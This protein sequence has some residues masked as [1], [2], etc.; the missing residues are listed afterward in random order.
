MNYLNLFM[1]M[2][3]GN[4][5]PFTSGFRSK[6]EIVNEVFIAVGTFHFM[7]FTDFT[8]DVDV[9]FTVG[10]SLAGFIIAHITFNMMIVLH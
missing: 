3:H 5:R 8:K 9:Q 7:L 6:V 4:T 10:W 1:L 2:Y